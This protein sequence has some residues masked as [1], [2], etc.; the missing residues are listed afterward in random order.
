MNEWGVDALSKI[1]TLN[2]EYYGMSRK[3]F[4]DLIDGMKATEI[5]LLGQS[6]SLLARG[7]K[8]DGG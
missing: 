2:V 4:S 6:G 7:K 3:D 1:E 5:C 8:I